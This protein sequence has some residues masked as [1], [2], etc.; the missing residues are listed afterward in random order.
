MFSLKMKMMLSEYD[1][2]G[3]KI[4]YENKIHEKS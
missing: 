2:I 3:Q 1:E 4:T